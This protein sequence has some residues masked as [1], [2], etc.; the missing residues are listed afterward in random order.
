MSD[1]W[2][3]YD[4]IVDWFDNNRSK[5]LIE[6]EYLELVLKHIPKKGTILDLGCGTG[7]PLAQFFIQRGFYVTGLDGSPKMIDLCK[8]RFP[9]MKWIVGDMR[10]INLHQKFDAVIA[11]D[12]FFHLNQ[13]DQKSMFNVFNQHLQEEGILLFTSG[14]KKSEVYS[15]MDGHN[16]FHASLDLNEYRKLLKENGFEI[17][18]NKVEDPACGMHTVWVAKKNK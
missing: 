2:K 17:L 8:K 3:L 9:D 5:E 6:K 10:V 14:P 7:E 4:K 13:D 18:L 15:N 16:F 1:I 12:S 11:W